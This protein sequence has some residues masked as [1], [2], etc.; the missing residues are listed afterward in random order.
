MELKKLLVMI[1]EINIKSMYKK[2]YKKMQKK[3]KKIKKWIRIQKS[4]SRSI[5]TRAAGP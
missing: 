5:K 2:N 3:E 1:P 4:R